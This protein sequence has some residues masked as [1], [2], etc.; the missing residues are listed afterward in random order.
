MPASNASLVAPEGLSANPPAGLVRA[1]RLAREVAE[2][3]VDALWAGMTERELARWAEETL[4]A[5]GSTGLWTPTNVG[6]GANSLKC[7]PTELPGDHMLWNI[8]AG[9]ID[10]HPVVDGWWGDCTRT[11]VVGDHPDYFE[12]KAEIERIHETVMAAAHPGMAANELWSA[13]NDCIAGTGWNHLDRLGNIGHSIGQNVSY[14]QG[15]IDRHNT[16]PMWGGW[17]VE[18]FV[19]NHLYGVKLEDVIWFGQEGCT[20]IR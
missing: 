5:R 12:A 18:P 19:G 8:D 6:F 2:L 14:T 1:Q 10:V 9:F 13:F 4:R 20:V 17:A 7:F 3:A 16:T 15:Y 11:F